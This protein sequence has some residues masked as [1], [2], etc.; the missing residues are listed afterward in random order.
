MIIIIIFVPFFLII[1]PQ[2][3]QNLSFLERI[4][5]LSRKSSIENHFVTIGLL[6][7]DSDE[8]KAAGKVVLKSMVGF[9]LPHSLQPST[10]CLT[11]PKKLHHLCTTT[12]QTLAT[13]VSAC[14]LDCSA[15]LR[16]GTNDGCWQSLFMHPAHC[17][18]AQLLS[19]QYFETLQVAT[20][21]S[22]MLERRCSLVHPGMY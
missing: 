3:I 12:F 17:S 6:A 15:S 20:A 9:K 16:R 10:G 14:R 11:P 8:T 1:K 7:A 21:V 2:Y 4:K 18:T 22:N 19:L 13:M 5:S